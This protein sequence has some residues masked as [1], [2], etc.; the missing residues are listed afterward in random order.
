MKNVK[1][2]PLL[3]SASLS[4]TPLNGITAS[5]ED[6]AYSFHISFIDEESE[7]YVANVDA[8]LIQRAIEWTDEEHYSCVGDENIVCEWNSSDEKPFITPTFTDNWQDYVYAVVVDELPEGYIYNSGKSVDYGI[9]GYLDGEVKVAIKL[10]EGAVQEQTGS[11]ETGTAISQYDGKYHDGDVFTVGREGSHAPIF[12]GCVTNSG[13]TL[14][15]TIM[16]PKSAEDVKVEIAKLKVNARHSDGGYLYT[17]TVVTE[18]YDL[19]A[20][21]NLDITGSEPSGNY[22]TIS[23]VSNEALGVTNNIPVAVSVIE[24]ELLFSKK[25]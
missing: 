20:D 10:N 14:V 7:E 25:E 5:A 13:K 24:L 12:P 4:L 17:G 3:L 11:I 2:L 8:K 16:L 9:S 19:L 22:Y 1:L 15:F 21:T 18:G 6:S 23:V